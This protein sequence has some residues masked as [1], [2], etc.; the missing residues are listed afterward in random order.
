MKEIAVLIPCYNEEKSIQ[1]VISDFKKELPEAKVYVFDNNSTDSTAE[2]ARRAGA[3]VY[4]V[5][6]KGKGNVVRNM[7]RKIDADI[8]VMVD[9]DDTYPPYNV[10]ELIQPILNDEADMVTGDRLSSS[11]F[12]ENK[13]IFHNSGNKIVKYFINQIFNSSLHDIL[14]GYRAF[15]KRFVKS[16]PVMSDG[17]EIETELTVYALHHKFPIKEIVVPYRDRDINNP[18]KLNTVKDGMRII[19]TIFGL[20]RDYK[21]F[22]CFSIISFIIT[23][24]GIFLLVPVFTEYFQTGL[25]ARFPTLIFGCFLLLGALFLFCS[26]LIL[27]VISNHNKALMINRY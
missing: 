3:T 26:G 13:R 12:T 24:V 25:V 15:S 19:A 9:G 27:Q 7:F 17:F 1:K 8:Y 5:K 14:T 21:P 18:S 2:V 16:M 6:D 23:V 20:F 4:F 10:K 22:V 11:Y